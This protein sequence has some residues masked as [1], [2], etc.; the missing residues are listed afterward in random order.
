[1]EALREITTWKSDYRAPN[2]IYLM[3]G[4][5]A[6][7][8]IPWGTE[9]PVYFKVPMHLDKRGRQFVKMSTKLF[10]ETKETRIRVE[11][12]K[13]NVYFVDPVEMTCTCAGF[14]FRGKCK[15][16]NAM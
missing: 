1:M 6:V 7:A 3:D 8:Y 16:L 13:G 12:S 10:K 5:K 11:G 14:A 2:H 15:H 9:E 4:A